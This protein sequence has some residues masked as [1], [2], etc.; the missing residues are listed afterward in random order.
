VLWIQNAPCVFCGSFCNP[1][2]SFNLT[3]QFN[4]VQLLSQTLKIVLLIYTINF[5]LTQWYMHK[6][7]HCVHFQIWFNFCL[8]IFHSHKSMLF[9]ITSIFYHKF[10][11]NG[12]VVC[13]WLLWQSNWE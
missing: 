2:P 11:I 10:I 3:I 1:K 12:Q 4:I 8:K 7:I 6:S 9:E 13:Q 5:N